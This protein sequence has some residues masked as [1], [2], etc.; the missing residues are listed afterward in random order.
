MGGARKAQNGMG[1]DSNMGD[2]NMAQNGL[3]SA[4][5][6]GGGGAGGGPQDQWAHYPPIYRR[7][8]EYT[9]EEGSKT[10]EGVNVVSIARHVGGDDPTAIM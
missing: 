5:H 9:Q 7:I 4:D 3:L 6:Q 1:Y 8:L 10:A 2:Y